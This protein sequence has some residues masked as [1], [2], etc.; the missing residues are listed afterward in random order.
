[1]FYWGIAIVSAGPLLLIAES[2]GR[3]GLTALFAA[4]TLGFGFLLFQTIRAVYIGR[5]LSQRRYIGKLNVH[6]NSQILSSAINNELERVEIARVI[7]QDDGWRIYDATFDIYY[8]S[9]YESSV[10]YIKVKQAFYTVFEAKLKRPIPHLIFDSKTAK[11]YQFQSVYLKA[12]RLP[13]DSHLDSHFRI[14]SPKGYQ[15]DT[16]S[17]ITPEVVEAILGAKDYDVEFVGDS[18]FC[19]APLLPKRQ[20]AAFKERALNI[21][22]S[23]NDN[24]SSYRD[25]HLQGQ[26][27]R[28][29]VSG[30]GRR[31]LENPIRY[32][33]LVIASVI[34]VIFAV[35]LV[36]L[37]PRLLDIA[38]WLFS[39]AFVS[40]G[41][42]LTKAISIIKT[43]RRQQAAMVVNYGPVLK[44]QPELY[45]AGWHFKES[46]F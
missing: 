43:N 37:N 25:S 41:S 19:Y 3:Q 11:G 44:G 16:L 9:M 5:L 14:Y 33:K 35:L 21:Y 15:I 23:V 45:L 24:L 30:F 17:I 36:I 6:R 20:L 39:F 27:R 8:E 42:S 22:N 13:F 1:M 26:A 28:D 2:G 40:F 34:V 4:W 18:L 32:I 12:Q 10:D 38:V 46:D 7:D 31:L 29:Q